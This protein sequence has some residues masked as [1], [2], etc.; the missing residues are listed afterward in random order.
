M[1]MQ[2]ALVN[3]V[4]ARN[5]HSHRRGKTTVAGNNGGWQVMEESSD[6][7]AGRGMTIDGSNH[8]LGDGQKNQ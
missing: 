7:N 5:Q 8:T 1:E 4:N 6:S 2:T 3:E